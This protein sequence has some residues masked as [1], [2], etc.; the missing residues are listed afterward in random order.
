MKKF[1]N[2]LYIHVCF[3]DML[4]P[5]FTIILGVLFFDAFAQNPIA[6]Y[7]YLKNNFK[8]VSTKDSADYILMFFPP[9]SAVNK[10][11]FVVKELYAD[12]K[13]HF[14]SSSKNKNRSRNPG[15]VYSSLQGPYTSYFHNGN[16]MAV[17][18]YE[19]NKKVGE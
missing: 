7:Y 4:K 18:T 8:I 14:I 6:V 16:I 2:R 13:V 17:C 1:A 11:L 9:D 15:Y 10:E 19:N 3:A 12:G 5:F